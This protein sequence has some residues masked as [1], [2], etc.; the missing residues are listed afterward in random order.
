MSVSS[1]INYAAMDGMERH[2]LHSLPEEQAMNPRDCLLEL[3]EQLDDV[4]LRQVLKIE[5][6]RTLG[7]HDRLVNMLQQ[8]VDMLEQDNESLKQHAHQMQQRYDKAVR[9]MQFFRKKYDNLAAVDAARSTSSSVPGSPRP[10][11]S[12]STHLSHH[13]H[14]SLSNGSNSH[15]PPPPLPAPMPVSH[16]STPH[17]QQY[18]NHHHHQQQQLPPPPLPHHQSQSQ[19][20]PPMPLPGNDDDNSSLL[21]D[22]MRQKLAMTSRSTSTTTTMS[23]ST[24][25][26][27]SSASMAPS[28]TATTISSVETPASSVR[29]RQNSMNTIHSTASS[30]NSSSNGIPI[31][32]N[33]A[34]S[35][36]GQGSVYSGSG[37]SDY[38][39]SRHQSNL[40]M[41]SNG[42]SGKSSWQ[43][44]RSQPSPTTASLNPTTSI[45][46]NTGQA[47][48]MTPVRSTTT[49][50]GYTGNSLLQQ[51]RVDPLIFGGADGL[52]ETIAKSKGSD[53]T[54]EKIIS[55]FLR[56]GGSPN[57][58]KQSNQSCQLVKY[59]YGLIHALI[60]TK[61]P[62]SLDLLLQQGAN[63]NAM[64]LCT[65]EEEKVSPCYLA[66][67]VG[68]LAGLQ[69]L[70][71]A[72]GDLYTSRGGGLKNKTV[73]H[74][75]AE[76]CHAAV[77]EYIIEITQGALNLQLDAQG[78]TVLHY[79][80]ASGHT[81]LVSL[82][83]R[84]CQ[85]PVMQPD[86]HDELPL[87]WAAR[88]G[89]L[90]VVTLL[91]E[92]FGVDCNAYVPKKVS[93]PYD[94]AKAAGHRRLVDYL[95]GIGG[96]TTKKMDKKRE[97]EMAKNMPQHFESTLMKH[98]LFS[99]G[100]F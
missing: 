45:S 34:H 28:T 8:R 97:E 93:T 26:S 65:I 78:A 76:Q 60:V 92:R 59:G 75:A 71:Q 10:S 18:S 73:L 1:S 94:L 30:S 19:S 21:A 4:N 27:P 16:L 83:A 6:K 91:V 36:S 85:V 82:L 52:W 2:L 25:W 39:V 100:D 35:V 14:P 3:L 99:D 49:T 47:V 58:A 33:M 96:I 79:A 42:T 56:R 24:Y 44:L 37:R 38:S 69:K 98:G 23:S 40:S 41:S 57:T 43:F 12:T 87:H 17:P 22:Q 50:N 80:C 46:S 53:V 9:E 84:R 31:N 86:Q 77:V 64:S 89:R 32:Q 67:K 15:P 61:A 68:W 63:P 29:P 62:G 11:T 74:V 55:N 90:E 48:P 70:V 54:V 95:K 51:R 88:H 72:G 20:H 13:S 66:A 7:D 81:D 5:L